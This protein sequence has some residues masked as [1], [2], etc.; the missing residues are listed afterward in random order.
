MDEEELEQITDPK[1]IE[2]ILKNGP[3]AKKVKTPTVIQMQA[4]ECGAASLSIILGYYGRYVT[5]EELRYQCGVSRDG[6][7]AFNIIEAAKFYGLDM[8]AYNVSLAELSQIKPPFIIWWQNNHMLVVDGFSKNFVNLNDPAVGPREVTYPQFFKNYSGIAFTIEP[9]ENLKKGGQPPKFVNLIKERISQVNPSIF[10]FL[11]TIQLILLLFGLIPTTLSRVFVDEV[12]AQKLFS[13]KWYFLSFM[14]LV[15]ILQGTA[16]AIRGIADNRFTRTLATV[17]TIDFLAHVLRLPYLFFSQRF[18]SE[19]INRMSLNNSI[20]NFVTNNLTLSVINLMLIFIY[21][22]V[23]YQYD[24][25]IALLGVIAA[26]SNMLLFYSIARSRSNAYSRLQQEMAKSIGVTIDSL[27][28]MEFIKSTGTEAFCFSRIVGSQIK[29]INNSLTINLKDIWLT[30]LSA[31]F[32]QLTSVFLIII[33]SIHVMEGLISIGMLLALQMLMNGFL[34]PFNQIM[35]FSMNLQTLT[36]DMMRI[37][38]V[39]K[40]PID[41]L[42]LGSKGDSSLPKLKG[43]LELSHVKFGYSPFDEPLIADLSIVIEAGQKVA[44]VGKSGS[45]KSSIA[46]LICGLLKPWSGEILYDGSPYG[47]LS[48]QQIKKSLAWVDQDILLFSGTIRDNIT[49]WDTKYTDQQIVEATEK[50]SIFSLISNRSQGLDTTLTEGGSN[51]SF[52][53]RQRLE[54]ARAL[55][56]DPTILILDEATSALDSHTETE[57]FKNIQ[58]STC[59]CIIVAHRLSTVKNCDKICV[60]DKGTIVQ[61]GT[62]DELKSVPGIYKELVEF[63]NVFKAIT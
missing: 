29:N 59:T 60:L 51:I 27:Q 24:K 17:L 10:F 12:I 6:A 57:I 34:A 14:G 23:M 56:Q 49:L 35:D 9:T 21:G 38:D 40:N 19:V 20:A 18:G 63:D 22:I 33:G 41:P 7:D 43:K 3:L 52:G 13:W 25:T 11:F 61:I 48:K 46:K 32:T 28:N 44:F 31:L 2:A 26:F 4:V 16:S 58:K 55:L 37:D 54:I 30:S 36:I 47:D 5:L 39:M 45:G 8:K 50:A 42:L 1:E 53:E 15:I 62:H